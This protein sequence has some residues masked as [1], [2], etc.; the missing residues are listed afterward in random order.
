MATIDRDDSVISSEAM[1]LLD[2]FVSGLDEVVYEIAEE[3][4]KERMGN[5]AE[6]AVIQIEPEDVKKAA[7]VVMEAIREQLNREDL[8]KTAKQ[9][10]EGM[11]DCLK[12]KCEQ[13]GMK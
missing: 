4:A 1:S 6:D 10:V 3:L 12:R 2:C 8:P 5:A 7:H 11:Y 9:A 13:L